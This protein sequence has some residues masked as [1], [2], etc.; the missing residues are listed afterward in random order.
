MIMGQRLLL[1]TR[2]MKNAK[3]LPFWGI[4]KFMKNAQAWSFWGMI[5]LRKNAMLGRFDPLDKKQNMINK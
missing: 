2:K 3:V 5:K 4:T 1:D